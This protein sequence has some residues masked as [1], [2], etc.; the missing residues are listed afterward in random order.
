M[1]AG[2]NTYKFVQPVILKLSDRA[3]KKVFT[4]FRCSFY[5][6]LIVK[7]IYLFDVWQ[8]SD[9]GELWGDLFLSEGSD[10]FIIIVDVTEPTN[11]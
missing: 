11:S 4:V 8:F 2:P 10:D 7:N 1:P 5:Y 6:N 3:D 9:I